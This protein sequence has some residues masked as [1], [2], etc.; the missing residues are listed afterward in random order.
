MHTFTN[1]PVSKG[2]VFKS[3]QFISTPFAPVGANA[4]LLG[5]TTISQLKVHKL[6]DI[7]SR[8]EIIEHDVSDLPEACFRQEGHV[9][10][11]SI[12]TEIA[13]LKSSFEAIVDPTTWQVTTAGSVR[14]YQL[15]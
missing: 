3:S 5:F 9:W 2:I 6:F 10:K 8:G 13:G 14:G 15:W 11:A 1:A 12:I 7:N 4:E